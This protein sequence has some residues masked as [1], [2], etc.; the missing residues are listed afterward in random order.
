MFLAI[1]E[2]D[3]ALSICDFLGGASVVALG[4]SCRGLQG[5]VLVNKAV[6]KA[7]ATRD[8]GPAAAISFGTFALPPSSSYGVL[9][10]ATRTAN[11]PLTI[12]H[13][14]VT[15]C[16]C[17][18]MACPM[19]QDL[20]PAHM[21]A[22]AA[23][24]FH[25]GNDLEDH[26][27]NMERYFMMRNTAPWAENQGPGNR[28]RCVPLASV[29]LGPG[30]SLCPRVA[31]TITQPPWNADVHGLKVH[32]FRAVSSLLSAVRATTYRR[33]ALPTL[34]TGGMG[35]P[36]TLVVDATFEALR[37]DFAS[38]PRDPVQMTLA[39]F[40]EGHF[41]T[42]KARFAAIWGDPNESEVDVDPGVVEKGG[43]GMQDRSWTLVQPVRGPDGVRR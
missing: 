31:L 7:W 25:A 38:H 17:D 29:V 8:F 40:E 10:A 28:F 30:A 42:A 9:H 34:G 15:A 43:G 13:D 23:V 1:L 18:V 32:I 39:C 37:A 11:F 6:W 22:Q 3:A 35:I 41:K 27:E 16:E 4:L 14:S 26:I 21:G 12:V 24:R 19:V 5:I 2:Q 20:G 33:L 36:C